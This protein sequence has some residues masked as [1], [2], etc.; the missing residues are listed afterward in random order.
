MT[1][2]RRQAAACRPRPDPSATFPSESHSPFSS[3]MPVPARATH[4]APALI[5]YP[6]P[7]SVL[8]AFPVVKRDF[9]ALQP[10]TSN[11][12]PAADL[13]P[14]RPRVESHVPREVQDACAE[15]AGCTRQLSARY[16]QIPSWCVLPVPELR[17]DGR[18]QTLRFQV[19]IY[20]H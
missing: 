11:T 12:R 14:G 6:T 5:L 10:E 3:I 16:R 4:N 2:P 15:T 9:R 13:K 7:R 19:P 20:S 17:L 1:E 18:A 8:W